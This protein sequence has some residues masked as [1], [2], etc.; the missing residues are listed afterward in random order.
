MPGDIFKALSDPSR[1]QILEMLAAEGEMTAGEISSRFEMRAPSV[2]HHLFVL[3]AGGLVL[4]ERRHQNVVY[5]LNPP[6]FEDITQ[7]LDKLLR[8]AK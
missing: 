8:G 4:D 5:R 3:K 1:R 6:V 2:S 7:W